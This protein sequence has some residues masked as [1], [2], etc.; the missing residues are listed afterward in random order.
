M[1]IILPKQFNPWKVAPMIGSIVVV[2]VLTFWALHSVK[3]EQM[4]MQNCLIWELMFYKFKLDCNTKEVT[5]NVSC[6][7]SEGTVDCSIVTRWYKK[8]CLSCKNLYNQPWPSRP[9][10]MDFKAMLQDRSKSGE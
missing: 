3:T 4:N 5:K 9:K 10:K 6:A 7:Q 1:Y 8:F 2:G